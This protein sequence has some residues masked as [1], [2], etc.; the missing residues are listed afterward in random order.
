MKIAN[1]YLSNRFTLSLLLFLCLSSVGHYSFA[2]SC[3][4]S[5]RLGYDG[6]QIKATTFRTSNVY[7]GIARNYARLCAEDHFN[8]R[9]PLWN[10]SSTDVSDLSWYC[11]NEFA[12][13]FSSYEVNLKKQI[14]SLA[15]SKWTEEVEKHNT[16]PVEL[17]L[18]REDCGAIYVDL[19][20]YN[21]TKSMCFN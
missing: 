21:I 5:I 17:R 16:I 14:E 6:E 13:G 11:T 19:G 15:C 3:D 8:D 2:A 9:W 7:E 20:H 1:L 10:N 12:S 4:S 18:H